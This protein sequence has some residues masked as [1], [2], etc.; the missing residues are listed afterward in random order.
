[1]IGLRYLARDAPPIARVEAGHISITR[2]RSAFAK[3]AERLREIRQQRR[4]A[5]EVSRLQLIDSQQP[6]LMLQSRKHFEYRVVGAVG[7]NR[8]RPD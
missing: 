2:L 7:C 8:A 1:M 4:Q 6:P 5:A 3:T